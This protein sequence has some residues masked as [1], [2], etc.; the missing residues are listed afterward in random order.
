MFYEFHNRIVA[1]MFHP[2]APWDIRSERLIHLSTA[3]MSE[4][5]LFNFKAFLI[6]TALT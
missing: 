4:K 2:A 6:S 5:A 3:S 1:V